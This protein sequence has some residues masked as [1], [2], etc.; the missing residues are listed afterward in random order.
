MVDKREHLTD[1]D[2]DVLAS[3]ARY[4]MENI[5]AMES[6]FNAKIGRFKLI[7]DTQEE[8]LRTMAGQFNY[9]ESAI[10]GLEQL[11]SGLREDEKE[12]F[13]FLDIEGL[14]EEQAVRL[15]SIRALLNIKIPGL[16]EVPFIDY[17]PN[18]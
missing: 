1:A 8:I 5:H 18:E 9:M 10:K 13:E 2:I 3:T 12:R 6:H 15:K 14:K 17:Q 11:K 4:R 7:L 16:E